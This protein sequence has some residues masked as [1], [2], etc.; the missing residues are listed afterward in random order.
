[1]EREAAP[2]CRLTE[3]EAREFLEKIRWPDGAACPHCGSVNVKRLEGKA[4]RK[5]VYKC[6]EKQCRKQFT[7]TVGTIFQ[8]SK[9]ALRDWVYA[10]NRMCQSK[11]GIS[12]LQLKRE[13]G[14]NY[15]SAWFMAH[16][17]RHAM[18]AEPLRG[19]LQGTVEMDETYVGGKPRN[20]MSPGEYW[21]AKGTPNERKYHGDNKAPVVALVVRDG[22]IRTRAIPDVKPGTLRKA[23]HELLEGVDCSGSVLNSDESR[24]YER[25][26]K[27]FASHKTVNHGRREYHRHS[28]DAG[29]NTAE[30]FF[31]LFKRGIHGAF[32]HVSKRHLQRYADEFSF[33]WNYR[34]IDDRER[35]IEALKGANG[36]RLMYRGPTGLQQH[37]SPS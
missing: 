2:L 20:P 11:K 21:K 8:G 4:H 26:G 7:V 30:S 9:I 34:K 35:T 13:L 33:R 29:I 24:M 15:R 37:A 19:M 25:L 36:R 10:F 17:V 12:A 18:A 32:H 1:M 27:R 6:R 14:L 28:D 5:G 3:D 23:M 31:G 22:N 16:R